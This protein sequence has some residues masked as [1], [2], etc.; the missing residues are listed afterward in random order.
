MSLILPPAISTLVKS[1]RIRWHGI[2]LPSECVVAFWHSR[3]VAG[4]RL[5]R[6]N[7]VA[8]VSQSRDGDH[9]TSVLEQWHYM[10][11]RGSSSKGGMEALEEAM[12]LVKE[13]KAKRLVITPDGPRGPREEF[14]RG[15]FIASKE[16]G[17]PLIF[18]HINF[19]D[20]MTF[21]ESWDKFEVPYPFS[22]VDVTAEEI[23]PSSFPTEK[24]AQ[25]AWLADLSKRFKDS[26][27]YD[28][29]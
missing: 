17:L 16:L 2:P 12:R 15:A 26:G 24:D 9:L 22:F 13:K 20:S 29:N 19:R 23:D 7:G 5:A 18:L 3:M 28:D 25:I 14:K 8:I 11:V 27:A 6:K 10:I 4:W 21:M 1:L